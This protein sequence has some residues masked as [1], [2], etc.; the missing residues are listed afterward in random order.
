MRFIWGHSFSF[1]AKKLPEEKRFL[2]PLSTYL[3]HYHQ[4]LRFQIVQFLPSCTGLIDLPAF[5]GIWLFFEITSWPVC[6]LTG[7][8]YLTQMSQRSEAIN[9]RRWDFFSQHLQSLHHHA[10]LNIK[11]GTIYSS[12]SSLSPLPPLNYS[13]VEI[14]MLILTDPPP[15]DPHCR[16]PHRNPHQEP[17]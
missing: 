3:N 4:Q 9:S 5:D 11:Q 7:M 8:G 17:L 15:L 10:M 1:I 16:D 12:G 14:L 2:S 6:Y 13:S